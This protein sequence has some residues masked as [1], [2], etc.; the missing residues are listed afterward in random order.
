MR[1][2]K[3]VEELIKV[4][5][6]NRAVLKRIDT[7]YTQY[8]K[9]EDIS[10]QKVPQAIVI[11]DTLSNYYTCLETIFL[12]I[13][14]VFENTLDSERWHGDL[15]QKMTLRI[16]GIR[17]TLLSQQSYTILHDFLRFRHFNRYYYQFEYDWDKIEFLMKKYEQ[18]IP[19]VVN[20][21]KQ[22]QDFIDQ[23]LDV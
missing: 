8:R 15:L 23:L 19:L 4:I 18:V 22:Y 14:Q 12:R 21:L 9:D 13:S 20:E 7:F 5:E 11:A 16:E 2:K 3:A 17:E 10:E 1:E 6:R